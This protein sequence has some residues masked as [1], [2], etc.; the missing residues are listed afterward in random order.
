MLH[1]SIAEKILRKTSAN[2]WHTYLYLNLY[3]YAAHCNT[4]GF[5]FFILMVTLSSDKTTFL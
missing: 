1:L 4:T 3:L 5:S 2:L